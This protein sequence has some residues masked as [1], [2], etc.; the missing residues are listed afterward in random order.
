MSLGDS[1]SFFHNTF[2]S[3]PFA[4]PSFSLVSQILSA[5]AFTSSITSN[6]YKLFYALKHFGIGV[7]KPHGSYTNV[8][9]PFPKYHFTASTR[10]LT[11]A[12]TATNINVFPCDFFQAFIH[13]GVCIAI[14]TAVIRPD[15][16]LSALVAAKQNKT[17]IFAFVFEHP[18]ELVRPIAF[19]AFEL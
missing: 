9:K 11:S 6:F 7:V 1:I 12:A 16:P 18:I 15:N 10:I 4:T 13:W 14:G 8:I 3:N 17:Y 19:T 2:S 5:T